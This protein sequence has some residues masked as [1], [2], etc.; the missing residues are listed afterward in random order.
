MRTYDPNRTSTSLLG[1]VL[2][3]ILIALPS[4]S[5]GYKNWEDNPDM[6]VKISSAKIKVRGKI[7][8]IPVF[9]TTQENCVFV[10]AEVKKSKWTGSNLKRVDC[11]SLRNN[12]VS[13]FSNGKNPPA[14]TKIFRVPANKWFK[15]K[16]TISPKMA[17]RKGELFGFQIV[18]KGQGSKT[19]F[20]VG[21]WKVGETKLTKA[22]KLKPG[23]Y[24]WRCPQNPTPW[25]GMIAE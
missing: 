24:Y 12:R 6:K 5:W 15:V 10:E 22:V 20:L 13:K 17:N 23:F 9:H 11:L 4:T 14:E 1:L 3:L 8:K 19:V 25:Y 18:K 2:V 21:G 7:R 16:M